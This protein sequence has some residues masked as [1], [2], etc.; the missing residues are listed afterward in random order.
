MLVRVRNPEFGRD[1]WRFTQPEY[2]EYTGEPVT[3]KHVGEDSLA[4]TTGIVEWP[5][6]VIPRRW[7]DSIDGVTNVTTP[8]SGTLTRTVQGSKG[9]EYLVTGLGSSATCT[10]SGFTFRKTCKHVKESV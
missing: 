7:I 2:F 9:E 3:L 8:S 6:R 4:L 5:V 1:I 10:C